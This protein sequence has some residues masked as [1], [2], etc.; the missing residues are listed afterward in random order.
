MYREQTQHRLLV[1]LT[2]LIVVRALS[3]WEINKILYMCVNKA[4]TTTDK[5]KQANK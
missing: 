2:C 1:G 3:I 5:N 4:H